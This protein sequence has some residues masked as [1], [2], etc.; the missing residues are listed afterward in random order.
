MLY[1][2]ETARLE[3]RET[4]QVV[5]LHGA[6]LRVLSHEE[7]VLLSDGRKTKWRA[8]DDHQLLVADLSRM[9]GRPVL[10]SDLIE[11][12]LRWMRRR[13]Q[14]FELEVAEEN[15][16]SVPQLRALLIAHSY[17]IP[18]QHRAAL[19]RSGLVVKTHDGWQVTQ[20]G[21]QVARAIATRIAQSTGRILEA[22]RK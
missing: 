4:K 14:R 20:A 3:R 6:A 7:R 16:I 11:L 1:E 9:L 15:G 5:L 12:R 18:R 21:R 10:D 8:E 2:L 19:R 17:P 22:P 13:R